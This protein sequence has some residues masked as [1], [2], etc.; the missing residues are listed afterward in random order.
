MGPTRSFHCISGTFY[1]SYAGHVGL[2]RLAKKQ[3]IAGADTQPQDCSLPSRPSLLVRALTSVAEC[4]RSRATVL[5]RV[6]YC[7]EVKSALEAVSAH[8]AAPAV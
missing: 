5:S 7:A 3:R 4:Q 6:D 1:V 8:W 2:H